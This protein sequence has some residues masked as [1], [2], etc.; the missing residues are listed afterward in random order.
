MFLFQC[1]EQQAVCPGN[2]KMP[3]LVWSL[4]LNDLVSWATLSFCPLLWGMIIGSVDWWFSTVL[5]SFVWECS[6]QVKS[7]PQKSTDLPLDPSLPQP[8]G[9]LEVPRGWGEPPDWVNSGIPLLPHH[10][11]A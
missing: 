6:A 10:C 3:F 5:F 9:H 11:G 1:L 4:L 2:V 7:Y 8:K